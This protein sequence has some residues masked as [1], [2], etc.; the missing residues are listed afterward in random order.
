MMAFKTGIGV[1]EAPSGGEQWER[2]RRRRRMAIVGAVALV[3]GIGGGIVG[4]YEADNLFVLAH[5][6]PPALCLVLVALFL[7]T[8]AIA[9]LVLSRQTDEVER[10]VKLK[11]ARVGTLV[12]LVGYPVWFLLWKGGFLPEPMHVAIY[13]AVLVSILAASLFYRFR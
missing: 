9:F 7:V 6:W 3:G 4:G 5:P 2:A 13:A 8:I 12:L 11:T 10:I 1:S